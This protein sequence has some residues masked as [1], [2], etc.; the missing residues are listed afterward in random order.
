MIKDTVIIT[1]GAGFIGSYLCDSFYNDGFKIICIDNLVTGRLENLS[2][3]LRKPNFKF[4]QHDISQ[5]IKIDAKKIVAILHFASPASPQDYLRHPIETL[6]AGSF[7]TYSA[8]ELARSS[9]ARFLLASTSEVYGN[10]LKHPQDE[11][12]WGNVNPIGPR[13]VYD[14]AKRFAEALT[15]AY[16]RK[17]KINT[18]IARIF[19]TYGPR[20]RLND[21]RALP[22]FFFQ[23]LNNRDITVY[24]KGKQTRSFCYIDD[25]VKG[26][27]KLLWSDEH[28]PINLGNPEEIQIIQLASEIKKLCASKSK[29]R[30][31]SL[32]DDDPFVRRPDINRAATTLG[33]RPKVSRKNGLNKTLSYFRDIKGCT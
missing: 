32:P 14:E 22:Q 4:L 29:I 33:W 21:G 13:S 3:L 16:Y 8:L 15:M 27:I 25:M 1:G 9:G 5:G 23:A 31:C 28:Q 26:I 30:F 17:Y 11:T 19:N 24:G 20:M 12:Y 6:K 10:P 18:K 2:N 7:G